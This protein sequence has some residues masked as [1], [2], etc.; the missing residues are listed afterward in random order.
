MDINFHY[1]AIK[2]IAI[3]AGFD[4][5]EAQLIA[6]YSQFVDDYSIWGNYKFKRVPEYAMELA[7]NKGDYYKFYTVTTGFESLA[8]MTRLKFEKYQR[9]IVVP[10]H[11]IPYK[12]INQIDEKVE[13]RE[14]YRTTP[15]DHTG[16]N[17]MDCLMKSA[18]QK[19]RD[20]ETSRLTATLKRLSS[21]L[22]MISHQ[23]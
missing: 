6:S 15:A 19:C 21:Q 16:D 14:A 7:T 13:G 9:D 2:T 5:D 12:N 10:F 4:P 3:E 11:F 18:M 1:F 22:K 20:S 17:L 8:D 23:A